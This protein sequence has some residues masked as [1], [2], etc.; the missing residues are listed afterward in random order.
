VATA[1]AIAQGTPFFDLHFAYRSLDGRTMM[2]LRWKF[3]LSL[4]IAIPTVFV[5]AVI[6]AMRPETPVDREAISKFFSR[7]QLN[8]SAIL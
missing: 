7:I 4:S 2:K 6:Q 8:T 3:Y 5:L 1:A